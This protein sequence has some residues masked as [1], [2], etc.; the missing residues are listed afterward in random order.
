[1]TVSPHNFIKFSPYSAITDQQ[2]HEIT[3]T[4]GQ[5]QADMRDVVFYSGGETGTKMT[6]SRLADVDLGGGVLRFSL[7]LCREVVLT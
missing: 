6:D 7:H 4:F 2:H 1:V 3:L 5:M